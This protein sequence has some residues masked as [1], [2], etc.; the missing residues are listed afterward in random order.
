VFTSP[1][2]GTGQTLLAVNTGI[3]LAEAGSTVLVDLHLPMGD[4]AIHFDIHPKRSLAD[5]VNAYGGIDQTLLEAI[6]EKTRSGVNVLAAPSSPLQTM[7]EQMDVN[8]VDELIRTLRR[9][10]RYVVVDAPPPRRQE[11][12]LLLSQCHRVISTTKA[13]LPRLLQMKTAL[14]DSGELFHYR[15]ILTPV[16][17]LDRKSSEIKAVDIPQLVGHPHPSTLPFD[18]P[19]AIRSINLGKPLCNSRIK[20]GLPHAIQKW[21]K[22]LQLEAQKKR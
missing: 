15:S 2:R 3:C 16:V 19:T 10:Y 20:R 12:Q 5:L 7:E 11:T 6:I 13:D 21:V 9:M 14:S 18:H 22:S 17:I 4:V 1:C 8:L